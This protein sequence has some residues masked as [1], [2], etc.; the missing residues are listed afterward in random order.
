MLAAERVAGAEKLLAL[1][2]DVGGAERR[3][4]AGIARHYAPED[5]AGRDI[6]IVA[7]LAPAKIRGIESHGMLLAAADGKT[8]G[9]IVPDRPAAS[10]SAVS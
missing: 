4:V 6:V 9:L 7:N 8:L 3:I 2:I 1:R 10:G 5:L